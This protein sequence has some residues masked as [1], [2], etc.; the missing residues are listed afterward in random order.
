MI[1]SLRTRRT[2]ATALLLGPAAYLAAEA[3]SAAAW[4]DPAYS[5][6]YNWISDLGSSTNGTFEGREINSPLY[7]VMNAGLLA[8]GLLLALGLLLLSRQLPTRLRRTTVALTAATTAGYLLLAVFHGSPDAA[9]NGTLAL[10]F[11]GAALAIIGGNAI[12]ILLGAHWWQQPQHRGLGHAS[13]LLG[14]LGLL[15]VAALF[16]TMASDAPSGLI[17]R[18]SVYTVLAWQARTA[19][20]LLLTRHE[21][22]PPAPAPDTRIPAASH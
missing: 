18:I 6:S 16:L 13:V 4:T 5:Y 19:L 1:P 7:A 14:V 20:E 8:Q 12:A 15:A 9:E 10:H 17:E 22:A 21:T 11:L 3:V 2:T